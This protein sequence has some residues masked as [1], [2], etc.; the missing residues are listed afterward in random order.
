[1]ALGPVLLVGNG[2]FPTAT[3]HMRCHSPAFVQ[4]L[5]RD[6]RRTDLHGFLHQV[7]GHAV[8]VPVEGH[9]VVDVHPC[10]RP[11]ADLESLWGHRLQR[12]LVEG[13]EDTGAAAVPLAE[14]PVVD[15]MEQFADGLVGF[16]QREELTVPQRRQDP[17]LRHLHGVFHDRLVSRLIRPR[18]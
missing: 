14:G 18:R 10:L 5:Y 16:C 15:P 9:V 2:L 4:D 8:E 11:F 6:R 3:A 12:R 17:T 7:V 1:M 13:F